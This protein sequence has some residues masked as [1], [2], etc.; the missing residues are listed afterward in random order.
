MNTKKPNKVLKPEEDD[1]ND[2]K[3]IIDKNQ[4]QQKV[5][6]KIIERINS[7]TKK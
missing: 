6:K 1:E 3:R 2:L 4:V 5:M 7:K